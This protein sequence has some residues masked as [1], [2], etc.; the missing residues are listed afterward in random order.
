MGFESILSL[1]SRLVI[2][3]GGSTRSQDSQPKSDSKST[4]SVVVGDESA[5]WAAA[6]K[7]FMHAK[8]DEGPASF[9][10]QGSKL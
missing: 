3:S 9:F 10:C 8:L 6:K 2:D 4:P 1:F 5:G 7:N